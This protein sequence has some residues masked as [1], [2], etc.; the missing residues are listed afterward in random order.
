M[1][2]VSVSAQPKVMRLEKMLHMWHFASDE[3]CGFKDFDSWHTEFQLAMVARHNAPIEAGAPLKMSWGCMYGGFASYTLPGTHS[4]PA[5]VSLAYYGDI[6]SVKEHTGTRAVSSAASKRNVAF[7]SGFS[8]RGRTADRACAAGPAPDHGARQ[9]SAQARAGLAR[10]SAPGTDDVL[11][12]AWAGPG[13]EP[14][15][16]RRLAGSRRAA[17]ER[18]RI[19]DRPLSGDARPDR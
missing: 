2:T 6:E 3:C 19:V 7:H 18:G 5:A 14:P 8:V 12:C 1:S 17:D 11:P 13:H 16:A 4:C 9:Q 15:A 10:H